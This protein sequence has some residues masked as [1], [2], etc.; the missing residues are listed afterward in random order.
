MT[1]DPT[2]TLD[3]DLVLAQA[4]AL[5]AHLQRMGVQFLPAENPDRVG[6]LMSHFA[7]IEDGVD[8]QAASSVSPATSTVKPNDAKSAPTKPASSGPTPG[9]VSPASSSV[10]AP[11]R[12]VTAV[13][14]AE[15]DY[16]GPRLEPAERGSIL[17]TLQA[18]VSGCT[19]C[20]ILSS[21]RN[22]TVFGE[23]NPNARF[24]FFGEGPG[25]DE[26]RT[27]RPFVGKA[28]Q[29]LT[30][31][32]SACT[33]SREETYI[34][35]TVKCRPPGNRNPEL[36]EIAN[37]R[38]YYQQQLSIIRPEYIVCL[39]AIAAQELLK[40]KL[41]VGRL[42]GKIHQYHTS[43]VLVTYHPAY[44]LRNPAAKKAA[45]DDLRLMLSDAGISV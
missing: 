25:A 44:L 37:C 2:Q 21:C 35:N 5:A 41:S 30:K 12:S 36:D 32:I 31:M 24:V 28:G 20:P 15:G 22:Q 38:S 45:W 3:P 10:Q 27:G 7:S 6:E 4:S 11:S 16:V 13:T 43:K 1:S 8:A 40:S 29:L 23:G 18:E 19:K 9:P 34:L 39:G 17:A 26:D 14:V 33:L 42:R